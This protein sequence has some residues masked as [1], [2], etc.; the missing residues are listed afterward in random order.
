MTTDTPTL[1]TRRVQRVRHELRRREL[2]VLRTEPLGPGFVAITL[3]GEALA[4]FVSLG[5]DDHV[6]F[7]LPGDTPDA[8]PVRRDYTPRRF[9]AA[10]REL[11]IEFALHGHGAASDWARQARP[12]DAATIGGPR[13]SMVVP[14]DY[15]W[16]LLVGDATALPAVHRRLEELPAG[17]R[18]IVRLLVAEADRRPL[19][20]AATLDLQWL[21]TPEL[22]LQ[23]LQ[24]QPLP[25][26][27]GFAWAAGEAATM[28][29][30]RDLLLG[31]RG[32][33]KEAARI[34]A[35]W[36]AGSS[37]FHEDL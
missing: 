12:G 21:D 14:T 1:P 32:H 15:D 5:F 33:P 16:H 30:V 35:Y 37:S 10:R 25:A 19:T 18:A 3:G 26:G 20:S 11:T 28:A 24:A 34:S 29:Q 2:T 6:K 23:A 36:R 13:G 4:D 9:D 27:E 31:E 17:T 8:E 22:L 7:I